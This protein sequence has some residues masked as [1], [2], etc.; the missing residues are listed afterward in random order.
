MY[1][2]R[3]RLREFLPENPPYTLVNLESSLS[4]PR[5][6]ASISK[7]QAAIAAYSCEGTKHGENSLDQHEP[8]H[9]LGILRLRAHHPLTNCVRRGASLRMT[10]LECTGW[11]N[12]LA[13]DARSSAEVYWVLE[14]GESSV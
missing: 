2:L 1:P 13:C 3:C 14:S 8:G 5:R 4:G 10:G 7:A 9:V 12:L 11:R 6:D